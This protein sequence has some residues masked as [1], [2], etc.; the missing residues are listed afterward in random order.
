MAY[1]TYG[2]VVGVIRNISRGNSCCSFLATIQTET[3][4]VNFVVTGETMVIDQVR[5]RRG[6]RVAAFY[7]TSLP[8]PAIY[9]PRYQAEAVTVLRQN[10]D[11]ALNYFDAT[12]T[13]EDNSLKLDVFCNPYFHCLNSGPLPV[14]REIKNCWLLYSHYFLVFIPRPHL[15]NPCYVSFLSA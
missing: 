15:K 3:E 13:A 14:I 12:L 7:D 5:L 10:Q 2:K 11:A 4:T 8:A 1:E 6:M 9:P